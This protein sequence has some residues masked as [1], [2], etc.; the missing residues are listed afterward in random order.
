MSTR[1]ATATAAPESRRPR[2][3]VVRAFD[4]YKPGQV[5][6]AG[7]DWPFHRA[8]QLQEQRYLRP[9]DQEP[10]APRRHR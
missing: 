8:R 1:T 7:D 6:E 10:D 5:I 9:L 2:F 3:E 4:A